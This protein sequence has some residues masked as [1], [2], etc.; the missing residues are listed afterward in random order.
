MKKRGR[1]ILKTRKDS[2]TELEEMNESDIDYSDIPPMTENERDTLQPYYKDFL[3]KLPQD[4]VKELARR[5]LEEIGAL[6]EV[7]K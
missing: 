6:P 3:D 2:I 4:M 1:R 5:R 7:K